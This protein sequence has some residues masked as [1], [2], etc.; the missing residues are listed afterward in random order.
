MT[1]HV[2]LIVGCG[3]VGRRTARTWLERGD[4]VLAITRSGETA[5]DLSRLGIEPVVWN[6]YQPFPNELLSDNGIHPKELRIDSLLVAVSH[7]AVPGLAPEA[8]HRLGLSHLAQW[9]APT[10]PTMRWLYLS[11]TGVYATTFEGDWVDEDSRVGPTRP[12]SIAAL[13]GERWIEAH[14]PESQRVILRPAGIYG[15]SR[16]PNGAPIRDGIPMAANPD[17]Y[18]NLIHVE[19]LVQILIRVTDSQ[20]KRNLYCVSD[21]HSPLRRDY[22]SFIAETKGWPEPVFVPSQREEGD[23]RID[24]L[25]RSSKPARSDGNKRISNRR[26][27]EDLGYAFRYPSYREGL[28]SVASEI[29]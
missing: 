14:V 10:H 27:L 20:P 2:R 26:L 15:P 19:D 7:A 22:Y 17:S 28:S 18:V 12:G 23:P 11:T 6:W 3:Y 8:T 16:I 24:G 21:G 13:E 4:R 29:L 1:R 9:L 25:K 5:G